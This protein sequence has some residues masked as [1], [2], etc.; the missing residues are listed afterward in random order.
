MDAQVLHEILT[1]GIP[2]IAVIIVGFILNKQIQT[3]NTLLNGYKDFIATTDYKK[4]KEFYEDI[5]IPKE[6]AKAREEM[7]ISLET[8]IQ[9]NK[10]HF[11]G[12][13]KE[14][15]EMASFIAYVLLSELSKEQG[16]KLAIQYMP[17]CLH[18]FERIWALL[19]VQNP[20]FPKNP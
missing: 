9:K 14:S 11:E 15:G 2:T 17:N 1:I 5:V 13:A 16:R 20:N 18:H 3:Q 7:S 10:P 6:I 12:I 4:A 8:E 19:D